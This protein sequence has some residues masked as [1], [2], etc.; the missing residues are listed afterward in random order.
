VFTASRV[1]GLNVKFFSVPL[2]ISS[3]IH[4]NY[5]QISTTLILHRKHYITKNK[6]KVSKN[7]N[8]KRRRK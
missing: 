7:E 2:K 1:L 3:V 8:G 6:E 5:E 4:K